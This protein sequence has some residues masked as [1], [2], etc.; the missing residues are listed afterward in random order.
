M[1]RTTTTVAVLLALLVLRSVMTAQDLI[2]A[3]EALRL[4]GHDLPTPAERE[5]ERRRDARSQRLWSAALIGAGAAA[6][7]A[8]GLSKNKWPIDEGWVGIGIA[9]TSLGFGLFG[10]LDPTDWAEVDVSLDGIATNRPHG[11]GSSLARGASLS[12]SC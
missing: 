11:A 4:A 5:A 12:L 1:H 6:G 9:G 3:R 8:V 2:P 10:L 7:T